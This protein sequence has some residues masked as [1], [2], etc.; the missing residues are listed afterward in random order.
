MKLRDNF[1]KEREVYL[2]EQE[3]KLNRL[4]Y[5]KINVDEI[6]NIYKRV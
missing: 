5:E 2:V 1:A 4:L 6:K 3:N